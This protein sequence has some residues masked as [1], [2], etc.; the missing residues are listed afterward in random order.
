MY[1]K[2]SDCLRFAKWIWTE[3]KQMDASAETL[4]QTVH[5]EIY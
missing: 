2:I 3:R 1:T 4:G 5:A